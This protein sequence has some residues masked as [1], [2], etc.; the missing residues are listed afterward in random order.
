VLYALDYYL[1][2]SESHKNRP[3][4][5][6]IYYNMRK[7]ATV[8]AQKLICTYLWYHKGIFMDLPTLNG[9]TGKMYDLD[10]ETEEAIEEGVE[11]FDYF[12]NTG[13][14][15]IR[16]GPTNPTGIKNDMHE[17]MKTIGGIQ[18]DDF[19]RETF[20]Y[21]EGFE[22]Q[23]T[24]VIVDDVKGLKNE[25]REDIYFNEAQLYGKLDEYLEHAVDLYRITAIVIV[26]S[27]DVPGIFKSSQMTPDFRELKYFYDHAHMSF[28]MFNPHRYNIQEYYGY[29]PE[30]FVNEGIQRFRSCTL[31]RNTDGL[32]N[33]VIPMGF[34]PENGIL[35]D[36]ATPDETKELNDQITYLTNFRNDYIDEKR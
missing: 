5:K 22:N 28:I 11:Y 7:S 20:I 2:F 6:I 10:E 27:F 23:I 14:L 25:T 33:V 21:D 3:K 34:I 1:S 24:M 29:N 17:Y 13:I 18:R 26:P 4:L 15:D 12:T 35:F 9:E 32:D 36:L 19:G 31:I 16:T 30:H 8:K